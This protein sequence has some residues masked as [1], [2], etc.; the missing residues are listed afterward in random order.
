V[1]SGP[2]DDRLTGEGIADRPAAL[3]LTRED[4]GLPAL[5]FHDLQR[6]DS[7]ALGAG[8]VD[9]RTS[10]CRLGHSAFRPTIKVWTQATKEGDR[11]AA[12]IAAE[13]FSANVL[14]R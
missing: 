11:P 2:A 13:D 8:G 7:R 12:D 5:R 4:A 3:S 1:L 6:A 14:A 10:N 9:V